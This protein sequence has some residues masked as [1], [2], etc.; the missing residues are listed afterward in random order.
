MN[1]CGTAGQCPDIR[2]EEVDRAKLHFLLLPFLPL[3][4]IFSIVIS[5]TVINASKYMTASQ[6]RSTITTRQTPVVQRYDNFGKLVHTWHILS[7]FL[8]CRFNHTRKY[9]IRHFW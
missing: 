4:T 7:Q 8:V 1:H 9:T 2:H 5:C 3:P 6:R